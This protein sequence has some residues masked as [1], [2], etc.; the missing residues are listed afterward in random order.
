MYNTAQGIMG[1][2]RAGYFGAVGAAG[3][4]QRPRE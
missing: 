2:E 4:D 3:R 1:P